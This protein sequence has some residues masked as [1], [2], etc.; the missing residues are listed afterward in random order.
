MRM[1]M[2][3]KYEKFK[4]LV[5]YICHIADR[6]ELGATKLNKILWYSDMV[7][8]INHGVPLTGAVYIKRQFGPVPKDILRALKDLSEEGRMAVRDIPYFKD[9]KREYISLAEPDISRFDKSEIS[10]AANI[11]HDICHHH[12]ATSISAATHDIIW[13]LADIG[14]EIP[15]F[16][17]YGAQ[18]GEI[19]E[20]DIRWAKESIANNAALYN[21]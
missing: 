1:D 13:E 17:V 20:E 6:D 21:E 10:L 3:F 8:Y 16:A 12:T 4:D 14:E 15:Y 11:T 7:S 5:H 19:T 2:E 9:T 18:L